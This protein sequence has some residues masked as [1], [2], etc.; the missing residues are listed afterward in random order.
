MLVKRQYQLAC[1][2][3][4][5]GTFLPSLAHAVPCDDID[6]PNK[7]FGSGGSAVTA[8]LR[9]IAVAIANDTTGDPSERTT[10]F[11]SDPNALTATASS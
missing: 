4:L 9:R 10:I 11:Y 3:T 6:L 8:T 5:G 2:L 1:A 7:I